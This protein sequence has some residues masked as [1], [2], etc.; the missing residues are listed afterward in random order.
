MAVLAADKITREEAIS[1]HNKS[2]CD[3][4]CI[5]DPMEKI[6]NVEKGE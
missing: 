3:L 4:L 6:V 5:K 2:R 1:D